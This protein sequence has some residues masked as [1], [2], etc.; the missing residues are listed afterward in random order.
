M[1]IEFKKVVDP[2]TN[3][4]HWVSEINN[5]SDNEIGKIQ[6]VFEIELAEEVD[7]EIICIISEYFADLRNRI[8]SI[9]KQKQMKL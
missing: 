6:V 9:L 4:E 2:Q 5:D 8:L 1:E 7:E 3:E